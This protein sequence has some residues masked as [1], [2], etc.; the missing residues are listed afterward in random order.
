MRVTPHCLHTLD[1]RGVVVGIKSVVVG[2]KGVVVGIKGVLVAIKGVGSRQQHHLS[3]QDIAP[4]KNKNRK[5]CYDLRWAEV[6]L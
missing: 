5:P 3:N 1:P 6:G 4:F 2:I